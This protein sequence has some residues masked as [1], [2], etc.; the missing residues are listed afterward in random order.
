MRNV[1]LL[2]HT[3][4]DGYLAGANGDMDW[5]HVDDEV[6]DCVHPVI[7]SADAV[8]WGRV[9]YQMMEGY[10]PTAADQPGASRHDIHHG[11]W[12]KNATKIVFSNSMT[13][14]SWANTRIVKG[15]PSD[16]VA[17]LKRERGKNILL[18]GSASL[19]RN[20]IQLGLIDEYRLTVNPVVLGAGTPLFPSV[21]S[22]AGLTLAD[23]KALRS[24]VVA[25]H[26]KKA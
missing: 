5:I 26:Y 4:L 16:V 21:G 14:S 7:D 19:A 10:W 22:K 18:I 15:D 2:E 23:V 3:S 25:L 17:S 8:I 13:A 24:G 12:L 1:I 11:M 9:T 20:F 6:W